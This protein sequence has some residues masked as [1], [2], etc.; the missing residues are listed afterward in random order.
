MEVPAIH[1]EME[2]DPESLERNLKIMELKLD[3]EKT[4]LRKLKEGG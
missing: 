4:Y 1:P 2:N 3:N